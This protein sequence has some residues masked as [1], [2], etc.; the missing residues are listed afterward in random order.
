MEIIFS[1]FEPSAS[2]DDHNDFG[3]DESIDLTE[4]VNAKDATTSVNESKA[5]DGIRI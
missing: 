3:D 1:L 4:V 5:M 2:Q